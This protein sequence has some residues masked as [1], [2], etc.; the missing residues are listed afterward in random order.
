[1]KKVVQVLKA[2]VTLLVLLAIVCLAGY[3]GYKQVTAPVAAAEP[4]PCVSTNVGAALTPKNVT[5][6][7]FNAGTVSGLARQT[8]TY[9]GAY[10]FHVTGYTN[11][12]EQVDTTTIV[13]YAATSPEV[14]LVQGFFKGSVAKGDG[15]VSHSVDV[16]LGSSNTSVSK[17]VTSLKVSGP[18]CLPA[19][20][21]ATPSP[22][23]S[24]KASATA[25][26]KPT[27]K[28]SATA[29]K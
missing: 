7:V 27:P 4:I 26:A 2:P 12:S 10:G 1:M 22:T 9:L 23:A 29:K 28:P 13:G 8:N 11:S 24:A 14:K 6:A 3:W 25:S 18:V 19:L 5:V 20:P 15:R 16:L 21:S 17:P